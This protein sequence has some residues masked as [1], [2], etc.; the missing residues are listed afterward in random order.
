MAS[1]KSFDFLF[2]NLCG[3]LL[4]FPSVKGAICPLCGFKRKAKEIEGKQTR[5]SFAP[6]LEPVLEEIAM[7]RPLSTEPCRE[8]GKY[9]VRYYTRQMRSADEGQTVFNE[10]KACGHHWAD[11]T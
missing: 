8:C 5:Y 1:W 2:C 7:E 10:C 3:T 4:T 9:Q 6:E 11:N